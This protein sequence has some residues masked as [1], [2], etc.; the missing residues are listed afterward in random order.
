MRRYF[1]YIMTNSARTLYVG[2]TNN[3]DRRVWQ[4]KEKLI[5]GFT[6]RY[7]ITKPVY[8]EEYANVKEA[9]AREKQIKGWLRSKKSALIESINP[10]WSDL[11]HP[12]GHG[13]SL[14]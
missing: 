13:D 14:R 2:V 12:S 7:N 4:H 3:L 5:P 11:S 8:F 6:K 10:S 1:V 9:I